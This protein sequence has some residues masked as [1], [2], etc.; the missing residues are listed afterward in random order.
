MKA[1]LCAP[2]AP[3]TTKKI[4]K[5]NQNIHLNPKKILEI[6]KPNF[7]LKAKKQECS[8]VEWKIREQPVKKLTSVRD[9]AVSISDVHISAEQQTK[10]RK[11]ERLKI[12][13]PNAPS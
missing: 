13:E 4:L 6:N 5:R 2:K 9:E 1:T 3:V 12:Q 11:R 10:A 8:L 7:L